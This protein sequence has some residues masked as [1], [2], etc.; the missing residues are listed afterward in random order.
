MTSLFDHFMKTLTL[1]CFGKYDL[2]KLYEEVMFTTKIQTE[3]LSIQDNIP[4]LNNQGCNW[5]P[6][7]SRSSLGHQQLLLDTVI[8]DALSRLDR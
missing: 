4:P 5:V 7:L 8:L 6:F 1:Q 2:Q 3:R